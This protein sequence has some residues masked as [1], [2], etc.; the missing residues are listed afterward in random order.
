MR[1]SGESNKMKQNMFL[2]LRNASKLA[3]FLS[4]YLQVFE[5]MRAA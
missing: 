3:H 1:P 5:L 4:I 2:I